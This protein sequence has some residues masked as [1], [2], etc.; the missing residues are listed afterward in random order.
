MGP[1]VTQGAFAKVVP[2]AY[3]L[4]ASDLDGL[5]TFLH[6]HS[7]VG[8]DE[9]IRQ[10]AQAGD[11]NM[12]CAVRVTTT[13]TSFILKQSRP[14]VEKYPQISAPVERAL[15]EGAFYQLVAGHDGVASMMPRLLGFSRQAVMLQLEDLGRAADYTWLYTGGDL[16]HTDFK[17]LLHYLSVLH[18]EFLD[19]ERK[20]DF[21]NRP[22]RELNHEHMFQLPLT[23]ND[24]NL[25]GVTE[26]LQPAA[27]CLKA[28]TGYVAE[29][30]RLGDLYLDEGRA[31]LHGD[32]FPGSWVK[33]C[34]AVRVIDPE[35]CFFGPPEFDV[36]VMMA[37]L[38]LAQQPSG[39]TA[40][41]FDFYQ[42][43]D[44]FDRGLAARFAGVEMMRRLIGVAQLPLTVPLDQ[45]RVWLERS[46]QLVCQGDEDGL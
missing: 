29:V 39:L 31:L 38:E 37:H 24:L 26:G 18:R 10:A 23:Q 22:M 4:D 25:D 36:G 33:A 30:K 6:D 12:N 7:W 21:A 32:Y 27:D 8:A 43:D 46:R 45:K 1:A 2:N 19:F 3:Y 9:L 28:D 5:A 16:D 17:K 14:W 41:F 34:D 44:L 35:F 42:A 13:T 20:S 11:G 40:R 15:Q